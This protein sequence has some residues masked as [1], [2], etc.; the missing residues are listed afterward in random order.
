MFHKIRNIHFVG[1]GGTGMCGIAEVLAN[2]GYEVSG[3][4]LVEGD[5]THRLKELGCRVEI[6]H[7]AAHLG[8]AQVVVIS[9]AVSDTNAEVQAA[10]S[11]GVP[12]I[13]RAEMLAELMRMKFGVAVGGSH[14]KTT[15]TWLTALAV[16]RG[17][18]DPTIVVGGRLRAWSVHAR[19]GSGRVLVAEADE[20]DGSFLRLSP[21]LAVITNIDREHLDYYGSE[22]RIRET[23][24]RFANS[25]P[26]Y[27]AAILCV[28]DER[29]R[30]LLPDLERRVITYGFSNDATVR[31]ADKRMEDGRCSFTVFE[32]DCELGRVSLAMPGDHSVRNALAAICVAR[33][34]GVDFEEIREALEEFGGI[35]RRLEI[36]SDADG[37][38]V[39][40]DYAHHPTEIAAT[41][42]AVREC[43]PDR[44]VVALFQPHRYSRTRDLAE[45]F[46]PA[47]ALTDRLVVTS[48]YAAGEDPIPGV[49]AEMIAR[50][51]REAGAPA[52]EIA[53]QWEKAVDLLLPE[54]RAGDLVLTLGA[55]DVW[56]A[57]DLLA[58]KLAASPAGLPESLCAP[59]R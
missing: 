38:L 45:E 26:F 52:V 44:R 27:G 46:G 28:D 3:S 4:D 13:P 58:A 57:G 40:D 53:A 43:W 14:G 24:L 8:D 47:L 54:V 23:F 36:R 16:A 25:V 51:A 30:G 48:I 5:V 35:A 34:L 55:G 18:L 41:L 11:A 1:I 56:K 22:E 59:A 2:L 9:S 15:T 49:D 50:A 21:A 12:V 31:A 7:A 20:S 39:I 19:L 10:R 32:N 42:S 29:T 6:G 17:G 33:D 37:V